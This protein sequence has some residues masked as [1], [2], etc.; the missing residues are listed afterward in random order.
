M[1]RLLAFAL[2]GLLISSAFVFTGCQAVK[3]KLG[4][5]TTIDNPEKGTPEYVVYKVIEAAIKAKSDE[6]AGWR[7]Y[8]KQLHPAEVK[9]GLQSLKT[10]RQF[11]FTT[12]TRK[13]HLFTKAEDNGSNVKDSSPVYESAYKE[14]SENEKRV[15]VFVANEGNPDQ[16][17]PCK[18]ERTA[19]GWG[20]VDGCLN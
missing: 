19:E 10:W 8:K 5:T 11:R 18:L 12:L 16:P 4:I 14:V 13:V 20:V 6:M 1:N 17:T 7:L 9:A 15:K 2:A 3:K